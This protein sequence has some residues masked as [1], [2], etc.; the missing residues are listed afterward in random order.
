[1]E[2]SD[3]RFSYKET[4][5]APALPL[6]PGSCSA[7]GG[8]RTGSNPRPRPEGHGQTIW[9]FSTDHRVL[10]VCGGGDHDRLACHMKAHR[11]N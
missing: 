6:N 2:F 1:M 4:P 11:A 10:P 7:S 9:A 3:I 8:Q 5:E